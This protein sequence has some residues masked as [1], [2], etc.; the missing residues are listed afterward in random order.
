MNNAHVLNLSHPNIISLADLNSCLY[1]LLEFL[2]QIVSVL[3]LLDFIFNYRAT[4]IFYLFRRF[5][6][7]D[8]IQN[9][10][11]F[12]CASHIN[13]KFWLDNV[14]AQRKTRFPD[15]IPEIEQLHSVKFSFIDDL[16]WLNLYREQLK[17]TGSFL[18]SI[19]LITII[20]KIHV[21]IRNTN[22]DV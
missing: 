17:N 3:S 6:C 7:T 2:S 15:T 11:I 16:R 13:R 14:R 1:L 20:E 5:S 21:Y 8:S 10:W 18:G 19:V 22:T 12:D 4:Y 9:D